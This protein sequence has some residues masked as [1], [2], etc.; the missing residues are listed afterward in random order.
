SY[1]QPVAGE[2]PPPLPTSIERRA[3][4][5]VVARIDVRFSEP[6]QAA[7]ALRAYSLNL[8][9]GG[10]CL[11]TRKNYE[12][13]SVL[14]LSMTVDEHDDHLKGRVAWAHRGAIGV[15]FEELDAKDRERLAAL[16]A[17]FKR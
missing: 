15:R 5:R 7:R 10:L 1:N 8:S 6:E 17:R 16:V 3:S 12:V 11:R 9:V 4:E 13:G 14:Q 2:L